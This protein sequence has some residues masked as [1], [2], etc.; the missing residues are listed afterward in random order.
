MHSKA[1]STPIE[2]LPIE[3][4]KLQE[5]LSQYNPDNIYNANE[6]EQKEPEEPEKSKEPEEL[7]QEIPQKG[8]KEGPEKGS[9]EGPE[10]VSK[11]VPEEG[12]IKN[13][14]EMFQTILT[15]QISLYIFSAN[16]TTHL[17]L[18]DACIIKCF[19]LKYK[20]LYCHYLLSQ[21]EKNKE[22]E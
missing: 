6:I 16:M 17:Q 22:Q 19:K 4:T 18:M 20:N 13:L 21:F 7:F 9:K 15:L 2:N 12:P 11:E 10:E 1:A 14:K 8:H 3:H 5:L